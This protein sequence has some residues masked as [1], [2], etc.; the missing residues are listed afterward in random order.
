MITDRELKLEC[1]LLA[2]GA[3]MPPINRATA[4]VTASP[5]EGSAESI[6]RRAAL[7][8]KFVSAERGRSLR[9]GRGAREVS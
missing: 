8:W 6:V 5:S 9:G 3:E 4:T 7:Y 2:Q 1:L